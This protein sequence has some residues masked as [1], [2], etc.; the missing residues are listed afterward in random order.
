MWHLYF[1]LFVSIFMAF[2]H[3]WISEKLLTL[4]SEASEAWLMLRKKNSPRLQSSSLVLTSELLLWNSALLSSA[5]THTLKGDVFR[6]LWTDSTF[7]L[8]WISLSWSSWQ[9]IENLSSLLS[10]CFLWSLP[11]GWSEGAFLNFPHTPLDA[12]RA[13]GRTTAWFPIEMA[14]MGLSY[15]FAMLYHF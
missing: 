5:V 6:K 2:S 3:S 9:R 10:Q 15:S 13:C 14:V 4:V 12:V 11:F 8:R 1:Y 7:L